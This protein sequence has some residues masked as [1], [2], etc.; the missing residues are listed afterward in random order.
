MSFFAEVILP[1]ALDKTFTYRIS[2]AEFHFIKPGMRITVPFGKSKIYT[3]LAIS[4]HRQPPILYEAKEIH[5]ILDEFPIVTETQLK[6]WDWIASYY[7]CTLGEVYRAAVPSVLLL[8]S[9]T[10]IMAKPE[11]I[12]NKEELSD[13]EFLIVEALQHQKV[14][15]I[16]DFI[17]ILNKKTVIPVIQKMLQKDIIILQQEISEVYKPKVVRYIRLHQEYE[18]EN[19]LSQ[20]FEQL[21]SAPKQSTLLLSY[22]QLK[23][24]EKKPITAKQLIKSAGGTSTVLKALINKGV[25]E[26][27]YLTNDRTDYE[28]KTIEQN[29]QLSEAQ[30]SALTSIKEQFSSKDIC[31]LHGVTSS[32]KTEIYI[33][34]IEEV[35]QNEKQVL[36]LLPEIALTAQL[37]SRLRNY[38]GN[39]IAVYH[40]RFNP[41]ERVEVWYQVLGKSSKAKLIIGARSA[42]FLPFRNLDL[43]IVDEEHE[44]NFKQ[45]DPA[46]RYHARDAVS[47]L[48][49]YHNAKVLLGSATPSIE[50]YY[51]VQTGKFGL[52]DIKER[53]GKVQLPEIVLVD[54][55]D[56]YFRKQMI[57]HLSDT[58]IA[59]ITNTVE[60]GSQVILFQNRRGFAPLME[61]VTCGHVPQCSNCDVSLTYHKFKNQLRCHYCGYSI[62]KSTHCQACHSIELTTKGFGTEQVEMELAELF[63]QKKISRMD[64]DTT[65]GKHGYDNLIE[66]FKHR[67][68]DILVG[69]QMLAKG[70]DFDNVG[71]VGVLNADNMLFFPDFR[72]FERSFQ[73]MV[74]VSGRAGR[75]D[76]RGR[77]VIQT[78]NPNHIIIKQV[79]DNDYIGMYIEQLYE[80][81]KFQYPPFYKLIRI[82]LKHRDFEKTRESSMW[83]YQVLNQNLNIPVLG[84]E[85]PA[86]SRIRNEYYRLIMIKIPLEHSLIKTKKTIHKILDSFNAVSQFK[87]VRTTINVDVY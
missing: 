44:Q 50:T 17:E 46:P 53:Y 9:E 79:F 5:Q 58:L 78:Y 39:Q 18:Q 32:G 74:Q 7:M 77:V 30:Q 37:V 59:D 47:V 57:G 8:E 60:Q 80:R 36:F 34:L 83:L 6:H 86:V 42:L 10:I 13:D 38:F 56:K 85:E 48:A 54:L 52:V 45:T 61:C 31:L 4:V 26:E 64:Q 3:A 22:F 29:L 49:K 41:S 21:S 1:L 62:P 11:A 25:F 27:Y 82:T 66:K 15:K 63:P 81:K 2:E 72:A 68:I 20:L 65:G 33:K 75:S 23:V 67:E 87:A 40:S 70:L 24:S 51:N 14:I 84:P 69:T 76:K 28:G 73:M 35:I 55:K 16:K 19:N 43:V 71:L 12:I